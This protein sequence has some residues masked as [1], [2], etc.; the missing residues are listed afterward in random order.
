M[1]VGRQSR[2]NRH[3]FRATERN[4]VA[5]RPDHASTWGQPL[6]R[7]RVTVFAQGKELLFARLAGKPEPCR[8]LSPELA[9]DLLVLI[10]IRLEQR[11]G[12][13]AFGF[14]GR[15]GSMHTDHEKIVSL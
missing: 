8:Q 5:H 15:S 7:Y 4:I 9:T 12:I 10:I 6:A 1:I 2:D 14:L 3:G 13:I 11:T